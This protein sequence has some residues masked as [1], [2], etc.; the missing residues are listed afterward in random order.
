V[1]ELK[2]ELILLLE[3]IEKHYKNGT[4]EEYVKTLKNINHYRELSKLINTL[5]PG[6]DIGW[7]IYDT[8]D[9]RY[10]EI[11]KTAYKKNLLQEINKQ[12]EQLLHILITYEKTHKTIIT[13]NKLLEQLNIGKPHNNKTEIDPTK[14]LYL[15]YSFRPGKP[16][17]IK[18]ITQDTLQQILNNNNILYT[19]LTGAQIY[20]KIHTYISNTYHIYLWNNPQIKT[21]L[22]SKTTIYIYKPYKILENITKT[23][24]TLIYIDSKYD[25]NSKDTA[26]TQIAKQLNKKHNFT[27]KTP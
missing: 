26:L 2:Q 12:Y 9:I 8:F 5:I 11:V 6:I 19:A 24:L 21:N 18:N 17:I 20:Y 4:I 23:P 10:V 27:I 15:L 16:K 1:I 3:N 13:K 7:K 14:L 22:N 25:I